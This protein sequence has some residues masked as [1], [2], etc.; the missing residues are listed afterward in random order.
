[1]EVSQSFID[2][3]LI[4]AERVHAGCSVASI[5]SPTNSLSQTMMGMFST[6][7]VELSPAAKKS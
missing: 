4:M 1:M 3:L 5:T 2:T 7:P 6:T